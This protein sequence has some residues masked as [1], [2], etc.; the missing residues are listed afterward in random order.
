MRGIKLSKDEVGVWLL[1]LLAWLIIL[2]LYSRQRLNIAA[3]I[4]HQMVGRTDSKNV[5]MVYM[6]ADSL[7]ITDGFWLDLTEV[8]NAQ[9][10]AFTKDGGY[11]KREFWTT[12]GWAWRQAKKITSPEDY[13]GFTERDQPRVGVSWHEASAYAKWRG[14]RLPTELEWEYA[15][16]T[17]ENRSYPLGNY[18]ST[19]DSLMFI[20][21]VSDDKNARVMPIIRERGAS[22]AGTLY[23]TGALYEWTGSLY[24]SYPYQVN[25]GR[26]NTNT[27]EE[28][29]LR[30]VF[31]DDQS[32]LTRVY[33]R[34]WRTSDYRYWITGFRVACTEPANHYF[35]RK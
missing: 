29:V 31:W 35:L 19:V 10:D 11:G 30:G 3:L 22:W 2:G 15:A 17:P 32:D 9:Y 7:T 14:C 18:T 16:L 4:S 1:M 12:E 13:A 27:R 26:K 28:W 23:V 8:T 5:Q 21:A 6:P 33:S 24:Q 34:I 20:E 25:D